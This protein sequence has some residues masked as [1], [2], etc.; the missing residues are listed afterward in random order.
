MLKNHRENQT[1]MQ[2]ERLALW[3]PGKSPPKSSSCVSQINSKLKK[4]ERTKNKLNL[5]DWRTYLH[6]RD[7]CG[8]P[9]N[10]KT[11]GFVF[12]EN[13]SVNFKTKKQSRRCVRRQSGIT[14]STRRFVNC[15]FFGVEGPWFDNYGPKT[16][17][18]RFR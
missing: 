4:L 2:P 12:A 14:S 7:E 10:S 13:R 16:Q 18:F 1:N 15:A 11:L 3:V 17:N 9:W 5:R 6:L 8:K